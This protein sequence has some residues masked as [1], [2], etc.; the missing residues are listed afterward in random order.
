M[1]RMFYNC[2]SIEYLN[3]NSFN[4]S[5]VERMDEMFYGCLS[6]VDLYIL[7]FVDDSLMNY[8]NMFKESSTT[9]TIYAKYE[10]SHI[11]NSPEIG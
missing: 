6:L 9:M 3:L 4:T 7:N 11:L 5:K 2:S 8:T 10:F 1:S